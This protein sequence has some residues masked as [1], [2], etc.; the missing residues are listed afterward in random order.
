MIQQGFVL[1]LVYVLALHRHLS[2]LL[3]SKRIILHDIYIY[4]AAQSSLLLKTHTPRMDEAEETGK[5]ILAQF[6]SETG[7]LAGAP[8]DLPTDISVDKLQLVCNA[9]LQKVHNF[10]L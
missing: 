10:N 4:F 3:S 7:E 1:H 9:I 5:R 2:K 6:K 8:F